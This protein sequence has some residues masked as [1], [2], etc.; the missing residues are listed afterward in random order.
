MLRLAR[1]PPA[2]ATDSAAQTPK[3]KAAHGTKDGGH[4]PKR[5][6]MSTRSSSAKATEMTSA[7]MRQEA[8][9][10]EEETETEEYTPGRLLPYPSTDSRILETN[11][12]HIQMMVSLPAQFARG[13]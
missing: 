3:R 11:K 9:V 8:D 7:I 4:H 1:E 2:L 5:T 13:E 12:H 6:R 10:V